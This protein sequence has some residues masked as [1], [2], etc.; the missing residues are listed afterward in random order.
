MPDFDESTGM[1]VTEDY[2][3]FTGVSDDVTGQPEVRRKGKRN[4]FSF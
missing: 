1:P 4:A 3:D 2:T